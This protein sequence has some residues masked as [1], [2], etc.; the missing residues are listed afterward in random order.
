MTEHEICKHLMEWVELHK[1][2]YPCLELFHHIPNEGKRAP[3]KAQQMGIIAG[4]P[5]YHLPVRATG[6]DSILYAGFYL[7]IKK[8]GGKPSK[9]QEYMMEKLEQAGHCVAW[10]DNLSDAIYYLKGYVGLVKYG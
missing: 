4:I 9:K 7:E 2:K 3:W 6:I 5:D 8:H 1:K 10:A